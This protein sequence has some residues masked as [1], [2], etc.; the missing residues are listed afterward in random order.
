[1]V[2]TCLP[3]CPWKIKNFL[4][5]IFLRTR[6][7]CQADGRSSICIAS[8]HL[9]SDHWIY[10]LSFLPTFSTFPPFPHRMIIFS[11]CYNFYFEIFFSIYRVRC[12]TTLV[13]RYRQ[14][15]SG[16]ISYNCFL[17]KSEWLR[18][19]LLEMERIS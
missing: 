12:Y 2:N 15:F 16:S 14:Y 3:D 1:M 10:F 8:V 9:L 19:I 13:V 7:W 18:V 17:D 5:F 6:K 11:L 4:K